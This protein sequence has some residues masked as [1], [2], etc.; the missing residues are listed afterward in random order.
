VGVLD[1]LVTGFYPANTWMAFVVTG[2]ALGRLDLTSGAVQRRLAELGP[3]LIVLGYGTSL[4]LAGND[5][6]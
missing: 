6:L 1:L 4:L 5:A 2:M 3:A